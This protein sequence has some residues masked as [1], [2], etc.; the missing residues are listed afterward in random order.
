MPTAPKRQ[1]CN[2]EVLNGGDGGLDLLILDVADGVSNHINAEVCNL[3]GHGGRHC[4]KS[5]RTAEGSFTV[6]SPASPLPNSAS[7]SA[8]SNPVSARS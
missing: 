4:E 1:V 5:T 3:Q 2:L 6:L 8:V 7:R